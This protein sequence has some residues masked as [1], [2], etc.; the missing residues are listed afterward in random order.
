M[1]GLALSKLTDFA[2]FVACAKKGRSRSWGSPVTETAPVGE[3]RTDKDL[4]PRRWYNST[5]R[6][7]IARAPH[8]H[9]APAT[10]LPLSQ[11]TDEWHGSR[12]A[13]RGPL[14]RH[15]LPETLEAPKWGLFCIFRMANVVN[16]WSAP[17]RVDR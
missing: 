3:A 17:H 1:S 4:A 7:L 12:L 11:A 2:T 16:V 14:K 8:N 5:F 9:P 13:S 10:L 15:C 6:L